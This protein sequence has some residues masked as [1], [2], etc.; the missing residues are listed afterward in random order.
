MCKVAMGRWE[1]AEGRAENSENG[2]NFENLV[3]T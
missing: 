1:N 3:I 2:W